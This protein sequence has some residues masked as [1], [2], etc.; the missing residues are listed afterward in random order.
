MIYLKY[1]QPIGAALDS[2]HAQNHH[3][4]I[5]PAVSAQVLCIS[6]YI[7]YMRVHDIAYSYLATEN[8]EQLGSLRQLQADDLEQTNAGF[9][10]RTSYR[11][12]LQL[13]TFNNNLLQNQQLSSNNHRHCKQTRCRS[14]DQGRYRDSSTISLKSRYRDYYAKING[15][16]TGTLATALKL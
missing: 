7:N 1:Y 5:C 15:P 4:L 2:S 6:K 13:Q 8:H 9:S 11:G 12:L 10:T 3:C 14:A 16:G